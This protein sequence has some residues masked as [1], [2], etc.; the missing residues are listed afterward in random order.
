MAECLASA[1]GNINEAE[2]LCACQSQLWN[3]LRGCN[4]CYMARGAPVGLS[5]YLAD[6]QI[7]SMSSAYCA[8]TATPTA[9]LFDYL[10]EGNAHMVGM[11]S[12]VAK[13]KFS[14]PLSS[15]TAVSLYFTPSITGS[16]VTEAASAG[17]ATTSTHTSN[18][19]VV[20]T[21]TSGGTSNKGSMSGGLG[22]GWREGMA[23]AGMVGLAGLVVTL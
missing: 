8:V 12:T 20:A 22:V 16:A 5:G 23:V 3:Q 14:D 13:S 1:S 19:Q 17:N 7:G 11:Y 10:M 4:A 9:G 15:S 21:A 6:D 2:R 18:G